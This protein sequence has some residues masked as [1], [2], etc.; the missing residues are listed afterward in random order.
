MSNHSLQIHKQQKHTI[1]L[2]CNLCAIEVESNKRLDTH[3]HL[4]HN[5]PCITCTMRFRRERDLKR[6]LIQVK[7]AYAGNCIVQRKL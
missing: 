3:E 4:A 7:F 6:H 1:R 5:Y 2:S